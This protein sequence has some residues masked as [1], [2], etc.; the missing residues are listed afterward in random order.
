MIRGTVDV[1]ATE[2]ITNAA[3]VN[4]ETEDPNINNNSD[5][6]GTEIEFVDSDQDGLPDAW[7]QQIIDAD[8][9]DAITTIYDVLPDGDFDD[10]GFTNLEEFKGETSP[11]DENEYPTR[12]Y[13]ETC[14]CHP[15]D[16][17]G[18]EEGSLR[19]PNDTSV[20]IRVKDDTG[21]DEA[22]IQMTVKGEAVSPVLKQLTVG[23]AKDY[24]VIYYPGVVFS[25]GEEVEVTFD[26]SNVDGIAMEQYSYSFKVES[27]EEHDYADTYRPSSTLDNSNTNQYILSA[28]AGT[29]IEGAVIKY[30]PTEPVTPRF[31]PIGEIPEMTKANG[32]GLPVALEPPTVFE[33]PVTILIPCPGETDVSTLDVY[34]YNPAEGW[35]KAEDADGW[36]V[37][38]SRVNHDD[39]T[40]PT[41]EVQV[42]HFSAAQAG[43]DSSGGGGGGG[44]GC[45]I[46][47]AAFGS[48]MEPNVKVLRDFRDDVL[49]TNELGRGFVNLYYAYSPPIADFIARHDALRMMVRWSLLPLI[50]MSW[51]L[52]NFGAW[53][54][55]ALIALIALIGSTLYFAKRRMWLKHPA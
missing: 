33:N 50:G 46:A 9:D 3:S 21:I 22:C 39:T 19:V 17:Q 52:V 36:M 16:G 53:L 31:G 26:A 37:S 55:M 1:G 5:S 49:L 38:G 23:D 44:G 54:S 29:D 20:V 11:V 35:V 24:W 4:S 8:P 28:D 12:P 15:Y 51:M 30:N 34:Y 27:Q 10:D 42:N 13:V 7:E 40:P 45:F 41:I 2:V 14:D 47:T 48:Y 32:V 18:I 43:K 6:V 25:Y